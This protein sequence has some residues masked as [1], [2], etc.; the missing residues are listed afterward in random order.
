MMTFWRFFDLGSAQAMGMF[1]DFYMTGSLFGLAG[2]GKCN[3]LFTVLSKGIIF[4][5]AGK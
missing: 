1:Q 5:A 4:S 2:L 3:C